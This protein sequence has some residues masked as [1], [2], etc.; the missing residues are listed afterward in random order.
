[1][2]PHAFVAMPFGKKN[3]PDGQPIFFNRIYAEYIKPGL[4]AAGLAVLAF[5]QIGAAAAYPVYQFGAVDGLEV[6]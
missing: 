6:G 5:A 3:G 2:T 4:E 1:M